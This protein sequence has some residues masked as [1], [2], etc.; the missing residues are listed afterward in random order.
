MLLSY[1][2]MK[3]LVENYLNPREALIVFKSSK[4]LYNRLSSD[5][6]YK[7]YLVWKYSIDH[8]ID[9]AFPYYCY[10]CKLEYDPYSG[11]SCPLF[12]YKCYNER[13]K[14]NRPEFDILCKGLYYEKQIDCHVCKA[15]CKSCGKVFESGWDLKTATDGFY[16]HR[17]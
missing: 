13:N 2:I 5:L 4:K 17:C 8:P 14:N 16:K 15:R 12:T 9:T 7:N 1:D 6:I 10:R 3:L 11:H